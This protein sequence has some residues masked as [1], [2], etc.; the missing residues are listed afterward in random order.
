MGLC[1]AQFP[2]SGRRV[3]VRLVTAYDFQVDSTPFYFVSHLLTVTVLSPSSNTI[4]RW[5]LSV[6][7]ESS[8]ALNCSS[9]PQT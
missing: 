5:P 7:P 9:S 8:L 6:T 1:K 3:D 4:E 2:R